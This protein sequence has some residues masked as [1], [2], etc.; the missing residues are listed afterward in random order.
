MVAGKDTALLRQ[1]LAHPAVMP[2]W[3]ADNRFVLGDNDGYGIPPGI[4]LVYAIKYHPPRITN[5]NIIRAEAEYDGIT[6]EQ[7]VVMDFD[8]AGA[9]EWER[10]TTRN[11]GR[12]IAICLNDKV[13]SASIVNGPIIGGSSRISLGGSTDHESGKILSILLKSKELPIRVQV[14]QAHFSP[15]RQQ[16]SAAWPYVL[17]FTLSFSLA[18]GIQWL[19]YQLNKI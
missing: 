15:V 13:V 12:P 4:K 3:P 2:H 10:M 8:P 9:A 17:L 11:V 16:P 7:V 6:N 19:I 18:M 1:L 14:S 5:K